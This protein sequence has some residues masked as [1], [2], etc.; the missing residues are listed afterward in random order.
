MIIIFKVLLKFKIAAAS[1]L[2]NYLWAQKLKT[3]F[4]AIESNML[5]ENHV[6]NLIYFTKPS[7]PILFNFNIKGETLQRVQE[8]RD[9]GVII[10]SLIYW[11]IM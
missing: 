8:I 11:H 4:M 3:Y 9:L 10:T 7:N 6:Q 5:V 1:P 2:F